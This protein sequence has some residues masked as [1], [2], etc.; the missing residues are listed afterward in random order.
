MSEVHPGE[1][2]RKSKR[3]SRYAPLSVAEARAEANAIGPRSAAVKLARILST[4]GNG[5]LRD[6]LLTR[7]GLAPVRAWLKMGV[8]FDVLFAVVAHRTLMG[9]A[10]QS[11]YTWSYFAAALAEHY[12]HLPLSDAF[13]RLYPRPRRRD[14][15][16]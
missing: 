8:E 1:R 4:A 9:L 16:S 13:G 3:R 7:Q 11:I 10:P 14:T 5:A 2:S 6:H 12:P 15:A